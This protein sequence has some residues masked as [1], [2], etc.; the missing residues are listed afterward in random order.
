MISI[1]IKHRVGYFPALF[2]SQ[3]EILINQRK[4]KEEKFYKKLECCKEMNIML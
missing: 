4:I 2:F 1:W 3:Y